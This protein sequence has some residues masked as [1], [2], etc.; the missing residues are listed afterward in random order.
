M[1]IRGASERTGARPTVASPWRWRFAFSLRP[2]GGR[3]PGGCSTRSYPWNL[4]GDHLRFRGAST[5]APE[6]P[7]GGD[8]SAAADSGLR[9][10]APESGESETAPPR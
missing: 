6:P 3:R 7:A 9:P 10:D 5:R 4:Y 8:E 1:A 2:P